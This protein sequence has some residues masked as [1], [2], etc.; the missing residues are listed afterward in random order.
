MDGIGEFSVKDA[1]EGDFI[2]QFSQKNNSSYTEWQ[3][4]HL[5]ILRR[6]LDSA[7]HITKASGGF[8][9]LCDIDRDVVQLVVDTFNTDEKFVSVKLE[10]GEGAAGSVA[11]S[12]KA[13]IINDYLDWSGKAH[14]YK[15][16]MATKA[17]LTVPVV[18]QDEVSAV[19]QVVYEEDDQKFSQTDVNILSHLAEQAGAV[20][21][22]SQLLQAEQQ[23]RQETEI[24]ND[25]A[26]ALTSSLKL[27]Q[28]LESI[29]VKLEKAVPFDSSAIFLHE[30]GFL[31][32][33]A[34]RGVPD[35][36]ELMNLALPDD[37]ELFKEIKEK[38]HSVILANAQEDDRFQG[39]GGT[40]YVRSWIGVPLI[41]KDNVIGYLTLDS[42]NEAIYD[43]STARL[44]EAL[45][46]QAAIA[47]DNA[48]LYEVERSSHEQ[49]ETIR[50]IGRIINSTLDLD[51][52]LESIL[53][54]LKRI[55][56]FDTASIV[57]F[58]EKEGPAI[59][60]GIGY[61]NAGLTNQS[62]RDVL[63]ESPILNQMAEDLQPVI[64]ADVQNDSRWIWVEGTE[65]IRSFLAVP[66]TAQDK[67]I[68]ALMVDNN[69]P[70]FFR[71]KDVHTMQLLAQHIAVAIYNACLYEA[72]KDQ[73]VHARTLQELGSLLST[74]M[75]LDEILNKILD[76]L[77]RVV[78]YDCVSIHL[79]GDDGKLNLGAVRGFD[80]VAYMKKALIEQTDFFLQTRWADKEVKVIPDTSA[81]STW[82][83][84]P[85]YIDTK[86]WLGVPLMVKG[87][88]I[89]CLN[90]DSL[91]IDAFDEAMVDIVTAFANQAAIA[92]ENARL[93]VAERTAR[94]QA[95]ALQDAARIIG[96][97][98]SLEQVLESVLDQLGQVLSYDCANVMLIENEKASIVAWRGYEKLTD[99]NNVEIVEFD[100]EPENPVGKVLLSGEPSVIPD[101]KEDNDWQ[102]Y[103]ISE[104]IRSWLGVPLTS[105]EKTIGMFNV[106]REEPG[107]FRE[108]EIE[109]TQ[110]F[111]LHASAAIEN[112]RLFEEEGKR[113]AELE[114]V[115]QASLSVT[116]S[117][118]LNDVLGAILESALKMIT[119]VF[120]AHIF[121]YNLDGD[122]RLTFGA[123]L[124]ADGPQK[125]PFSEPRSD[126]LTYNVARSGE[127]VVVPDM[128][129]HPLY[130]DAPAEWKGAIIGLPLEFGQRVVG[131]MNLSYK[132]PKQFSKSE[133]RVLR[134]LG[135]Q[136]AIAIENARLYEQSAREHRHVK[137]LYE[138][139]QELTASLNADEILERAVTLTCKALNGLVGHAFIYLPDENRLSIRAIYGRPEESLT[140]LDT[141]MPLALGQGLAGW[142]AQHR[143]AANVP[144]V[145][146]DD[147]WLHVKGVDDD[148]VSAICAPII[149][150]ENLFGVLTVLHQQPNAFSDDHLTLI[151]ALCQE[152]GLAISNATR[153]QEVERRL[154]E[155]TLIQNLTQAFNQRLELQVL[156]DEVV[157][158]LSHELEYNQVEIYLMEGGNL[159]LRAY[160]G[161]EPQIQDL[162]LTNGIVG[163]VARTGEDILIPDVSLEPDYLQDIED[164]VAELAV[165]IFRE[166][167]VVG[168]INIES[169]SPGELDEQD[170][171][172][173]Q[174]LAGQIS[175]AYENAVL[176]EKV[177]S[178]SE[179][180]EDMV[181][182]RTTELSELYEM[183]QKIGFTLSYRDLLG[184][185]LSHLRNAMKSDLVAGCL[186]INGFQSIMVET[187]RS[188]APSAINDIR[189]SLQNI[190]NN[191]DEQIHCDLGSIPF[192]VNLD[193]GSQQ[194]GDQ[195][196]N[197]D[198]LIQSPIMIGQDMVGVLLVDGQEEQNVRKGK[199]RLLSTFANQ[200]AISIQ[201]LTAVLAAEQKRLEGLVEH[202]PVGVLLLDS[203]HHLLVSNPLGNEILKVLN[204]VNDEGL[205][206]NLGVCPVQDIIDRHEDLVPI[207]IEIDGTPNRYFEVQANPIGGQHKQWILVIREITQERDS[208]ARVQ[209]QERL[210]TV[211][212]LAAGIAHDF[213]NIMAA[214]QVYTDLMS[215]N[216]DMSRTS[217]ER[218]DIINKQVQRASSLIRQILDFSRRSV[219]EQINLDLLPFIKELDKMLRRVIPETIDLELSYQNDHYMVTADPTRL[220]QVFMNLALNARD[221]M[222]DGGRL[223]FRLDRYKL[224]K[225]DKAPI[226]VM[227]PGEWVRV[228]VSDTGIGIPQEIRSHIFEPFYTT[229]PVGVGTGLGLAQVYGIVKQHNGFIDVN[230]KVGEGSTFK[231]YLPDLQRV[232]IN[233]ASAPSQDQIEGVGETILLVEDDLVTLQAMQD[234]LEA[235]NYTVLTAMN[236]LEALESFESKIDSIQL[237][238]SDI[239]MPKMGGIDLYKNLMQRKPELK[240]MFVTGHPLE[241]EGQSLLE[242]GA[243]IWLQ[244]PFSMDEFTQLVQKILL[245]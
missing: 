120:N 74:Q 165:P 194:I 233:S 232:E 139:G 150:S 163:R 211:G 227:P 155:I 102:S 122:E 146:K 197:L 99:P 114:A 3:E 24:L 145:T 200:A 54:Q 8:V 154:A 158:Q 64:I 115:R 86:S 202:L 31:R 147:R 11:E 37:G 177:L 205:L 208:K 103:E 90:L 26:R 101:T 33:V 98:L 218:L 162:E 143:Q 136:A 88:F 189:S 173:L 132:K 231:I 51:E 27:D 152:I 234:L 137:L 118:E 111:A 216:P 66:V 199:E 168:V 179:D 169:A 226:P 84:F 138:V 70:N 141:A 34:A 41:V 32:I 235:H 92:I 49:S 153:Y 81:D 110:M 198:F 57:L 221:A 241:G 236:G 188:V 69:K 113:A 2:Q 83:N 203:D 40:D 192:E 62:A 52:I 5:P 20:Y 48:R 215:Q 167:S 50:E 12:G 76:L 181:V 196:T 219:I 42:R 220:Q 75:G 228:T 109:L 43:G 124:W 45:A 243:V 134:M 53:I 78:E 176:F 125:K 73:L 29:L 25:A 151:Q 28:V 39:W 207:E 71:E 131:V 4:A 19:L 149:S 67:M 23:F 16:E 142:A 17:L 140:E 217:Q 178:H 182:Q 7:I 186:L 190:I 85:G 223:R 183:S 164:T 94:E 225:D 106:D 117:L 30:S 89:G 187:T 18:W 245:E 127:A 212:Q 160:F 59:I 201:R 79:L 185:L 240:M 93:F 96:S 144:D 63:T 123:A 210:A 6:V 60:S 242:A 9:Y 65:H 130:E 22:Y 10:Y 21:A 38:K 230:S 159:R 87:K 91:S 55:L 191:G 44:V 193:E 209:M 104:Q 175:I 174:V 72:E 47:I 239:V 237:V 46:N 121:L 77:A 161:K 14:F 35:K 184:L 156:L 15:D 107:D 204:A 229:K 36:E 238:I 172:L 13:L 148:V 119:D 157:A 171:K 244:K 61:K 166:G 100:I 129:K 206:T 58:N 95:E 116:T 128:Q 56:V 80:D 170:R 222:P 214:I 105:R 82:Q 1:K 112:A 135:D 133:L 108:D 97:T 224:T 180:L 195:I 68:A 126:G 213:N